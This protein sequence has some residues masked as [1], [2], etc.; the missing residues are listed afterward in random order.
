MARA[1]ASDSG[2]QTTLALLQLPGLKGH[3]VGEEAPGPARASR[4]RARGP[5]AVPRTGRRRHGRWVPP[6]CWALAPQ[7]LRTR[8]CPLSS[9]WPREGSPQTGRPQMGGCPR[10]RTARTLQGWAV[11][12]WAGPAFRQATP[13]SGSPAQPGHSPRPTDSHTARR[14]HSWSC[15]GENHQGRGGEWCR[16]GHT[17]TAADGLPQPAN[18][19]RPGLGGGVRSAQPRAPQAPSTCRGRGN[20]GREARWTLHGWR[21]E[22]RRDF[23]TLAP[24]GP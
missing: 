3:A 17:G 1:W 6:P 18:H 5:A 2:N 13:L 20:T 8:A 9:N 12:G 23:V 19:S 24:E 16:A 4:R 21:H 22:G 10:I 11:P 15:T 7:T 14:G